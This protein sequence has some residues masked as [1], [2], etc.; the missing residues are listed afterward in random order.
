[1]ERSSRKQKTL[2]SLPVHCLTGDDLAAEGARGVRSG[3]NSP[4]NDHNRF[5]SSA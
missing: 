4:S 3:F 5:L 1:M 2:R